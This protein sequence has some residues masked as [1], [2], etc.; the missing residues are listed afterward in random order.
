MDRLRHLDCFT[1]NCLPSLKNCLVHGEGLL[2]TDEVG[3]QYYDLSSST[4]NMALGHRYP[5]ITKA[6]KNQ[7]DKIWFVS[8]NFQNPAYYELAQLLT[9]VAPE[10]ISAV[11]LRLCNGADAVD[12]AIKIARLY[13][14]RKKLLCSRWAWHG[15]SLGT[16]PLSSCNNYHQYNIQNDIL[17]SSEPCLESLIDLIKG[18]PDAAAVLIDPIGTSV[19]LFDPPTI[20]PSLKEIRD[21]CTQNGIILIFDEIQT[22]GGYMGTTLFASDYYGVTPD[23]ICIGKA[24]SAGIAQ[25]ATL[26]RNFLRGVVCKKEGEYTFGGQPLGCIAS[27]ESIK[28]F[29]AISQ[30]ICKNLAAFTEAIKSLSD[31]FPMI[32]F[33]QIGFFVTIK[34]K[35]CCIENW[36]KG[37]HSLGLEKGLLLRNNHNRCVIL[38]PPVIITPEISKK[39]AEILKEVFAIACKEVMKPSVYYEDLLKS[40]ASIKTLTRVRKKSPVLTEQKEVQALLTA[41]KSTLSIQACTA[42]EEVQLVQLLRKNGIPALEV[43]VS[44]EGEYVE[45][46]HQPGIQLD[47]FIANEA[48]PSIVNSVILQHQRFVE[49]AHDS[50]LSIANRNPSNAI[51]TGVNYGVVLV[52]FG[53]QYSDSSG[54]KE[55]LFAFEEVFS[56]FLCLSTVTSAPFQEDLA[57]RLC[58]AVTKRQKSLAHFMW[59]TISTFYSSSPQ[60]KNII[61]IM[62]EAF[63]NVKSH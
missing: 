45:Y 34:P 5:A 56:I 63:D 47:K 42:V 21:L 51:V 35:E 41:V 62:T 23:I 31:S 2:I 38:K 6:V 28:S 9:N 27:I 61:K 17:Y 53:Y 33:R 18:N 32:E 25:S 12:Y 60:Y 19:G 1:L 39:S 48:D 36:V 59:E 4:L 10:G 30:I 3:K 50:G 58:Y 44:P 13:T 7:M 29:T 26:C 8:T 11:N 40:G 54:N 46:L 52:D 16:L 22:F 15:E 20:K 43:M 14:L 57:K 24:L 49:M 37:I 55:S